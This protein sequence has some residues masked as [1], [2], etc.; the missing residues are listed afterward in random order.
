[1]PTHL[2]VGRAQTY[3]ALFAA[4]NYLDKSKFEVLELFPVGNG[5]H[6]ILEALASNIDQAKAD[7]KDWE[8]K[9]SKDKIEFSEL[10]FF[11]DLDDSIIDSY[12]SLH[13]PE[14]LPEGFAIIE[15]NSLSN[16][17]TQAKATVSLGAR[18]FD[19]RFLKGSEPKAF[20]IVSGLVE[21]PSI[22]MEGVTVTYLPKL[23]DVN[24]SFLQSV[25]RLHKV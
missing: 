20:C 11:S 25:T 23:N 8:L 4:V 24:L 6:L 18:I 22:T 10:Q 16:I 9:I 3:G 13:T 17:L 21:K 2:I 5:G 7:F 12:L 19:L 14:L 15:S 1:M